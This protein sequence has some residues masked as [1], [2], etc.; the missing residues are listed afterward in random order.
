MPHAHIEIE[1][2]PHVIGD[3]REVMDTAQPRL[4]VGY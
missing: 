1:R 2:D 3:E 4:P